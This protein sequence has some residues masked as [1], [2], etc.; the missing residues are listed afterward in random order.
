MRKMPNRDEGRQPTTRTFLECPREGHHVRTPP[1]QLSV[2]LL[3]CP[4]P[5]FLVLPCGL[6]LG[7][8]DHARIVVRGD[9][10]N[11]LAGGSGSDTCR[12]TGWCGVSSERSN[13][14]VRGQNILDGCKFV[15]LL[16]PEKHIVSLISYSESITD[17]GTFAFWTPHRPHRTPTS[18]NNKSLKFYFSTNI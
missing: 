5:R 6:F 1:L 7:D 18:P 10:T 14:S 17:G 2:P 12:H 15:T 9:R 8:F 16:R 11:H 13:A 3:V 4:K